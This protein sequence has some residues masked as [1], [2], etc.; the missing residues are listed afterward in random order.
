MNLYVPLLPSSRSGSS[1][2]TST[3]SV[4]CD[5]NAGISPSLPVKIPQ[6]CAARKLPDPPRS[7]WPH[8][9]TSYPLQISRTYN[10]S[11]R[12][13]PLDTT[14]NSQGSWQCPSLPGP[15]TMICTPRDTSRRPNAPRQSACRP[16]SEPHTP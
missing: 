14:D 13:L 15:P 8:P 2:A 11:A 4:E 10:S 16:A 3:V 7:S 5:L 6:P 1:H 12:L 9:N